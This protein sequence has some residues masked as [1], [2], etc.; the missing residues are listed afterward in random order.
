M[1]ISFLKE[2]ELKLFIDNTG[3]CSFINAS[4]RAFWFINDII[5][6]YLLVISLEHIID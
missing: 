5:R 4:N 6:A 1:I 2:L 3:A